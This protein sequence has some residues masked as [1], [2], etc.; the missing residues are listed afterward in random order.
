MR[1]TRHLDAELHVLVF[2]KGLAQLDVLAVLEIAQELVQLLVRERAAGH[3]L[4]VVLAAV[5]GRAG[6]S[7]RSLVHLRATHYVQT[8]AKA[9]ARERAVIAVHHARVR[10]QDTAQQVAALIQ[11][12]DY[13]GV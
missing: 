12:I 11:W 2:A 8:V 10:A 6:A 1:P 3:V 7:V 4:V 13:N 5:L 9:T